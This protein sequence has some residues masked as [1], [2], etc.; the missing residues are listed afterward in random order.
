VT[1]NRIHRNPLEIYPNLAPKTIA[2]MVR[3]SSWDEPDKGATEKQPFAVVLHDVP[4]CELRF[5]C[6]GRRPPLP[7]GVPV[8]AHA[9]DGRSSSFRS[10]SCQMIPAMKLDSSFCNMGSM[11]TD[12]CLLRC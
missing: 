5:F 12:P 10:L 3:R 2:R 7:D 9:T 8:R 4:S 6:S 1:T 11:D